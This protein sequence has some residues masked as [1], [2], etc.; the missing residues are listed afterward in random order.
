MMEIP[1]DV[2]GVVSVGPIVVDSRPVQEQVARGILEARSVG[3][4]FQRLGF[5]AR[6]DLA[7]RCTRLGDAIVQAIADSFGD[8][9]L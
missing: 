6:A 5:I 7:W 4:A 1:A 3:F 8:D 9:A 2:S